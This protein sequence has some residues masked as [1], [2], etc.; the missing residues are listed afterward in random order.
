MTD[1]VDYIERIVPSPCCVTRCHKEGCRVDLR[2][3]P[4]P[5][6]LIDMDCDLLNIEEGS[7]R[8]DFLFASKGDGNVSGWV[9]AL[10]LKGR[11]RA[12]KVVAQLQ[13]GAQ[14]AERILPSDVEIQFRPVLFYSGGLRGAEL[15]RLRSSSIRFRHPTKGIV[16]KE[17]VILKSCGSRLK[18]ALG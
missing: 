2:Q 1:L 8:C 12:S 17:K 7:S 10:E 9:G 4:S 11:P 14:F 18:D 5:F 3:V 13:A 16:L 15:T 6:V